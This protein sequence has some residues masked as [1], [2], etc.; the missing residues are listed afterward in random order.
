MVVLDHYGH[1]GGMHTLPFTTRTGRAA[2]YNGGCL[3]ISSP[4]VFLQTLI[5]LWRPELDGPRHEL[6]FE[7]SNM[8]SKLLEPLHARMNPLL[9]CNLYNTMY[10]VFDVYWFVSFG[11]CDDFVT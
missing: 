10:E 7:K 2:S 11:A 9:V 5:L 8:T 4:C 3:G 6:E 1:H